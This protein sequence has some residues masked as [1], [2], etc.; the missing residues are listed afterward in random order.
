MFVFNR[1]GEGFCENRREAMLRGASKE[2]LFPSFLEESSCLVR[3]GRQGK[4]H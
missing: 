1:I 2:M 3:R 4:S